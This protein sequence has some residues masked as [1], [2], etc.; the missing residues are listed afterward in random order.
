M[1]N[2]RLY[3]EKN[4]QLTQ[5]ETIGNTDLQ[6]NQTELAYRNLNAGFFNLEPCF[7]CVLS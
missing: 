5:F 3:R 2:D 7:C 6:E 1:S 4:L